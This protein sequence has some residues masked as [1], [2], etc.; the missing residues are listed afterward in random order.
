MSVRFQLY[1]LLATVGICLTLLRPETGLAEDFLEQIHNI[2][3][4]QTVARLERPNGMQ[5]VP[6]L[7]FAWDRKNKKTYFIDSN[8]HRFHL[9]FLRSHY[10][11]TES[12]KAFFEHQYVS[13]NRRWVLGAIAWQPV[14][15]RY[16]FELWEG[17]TADAKLID[18]TRRV[19]Q[20]AFYA[21]LSFKANSAAQERTIAEVSNLDVVKLSQLMPKQAVQAIVTGNVVGRLRRSQGKLDET[22]RREEIL[23]LT[24]VPVTLPPVSGIISGVQSSPLSHLNMLTRMW[25]APNVYMAGAVERFASLEGQWVALKVTKNNVTVQPASAEAIALR[26]ATLRSRH[27]TQLP[28]AKIESPGFLDL[29]NSQCRDV[30][31]VGAKAANLAKLYQARLS[32]VQVPPGY[33]IPF[34]YYSEFAQSFGMRQ[35]VDAMLAMAD[36]QA[37]ANARQTALKK[38]RDEIERAPLSEETEKQIRQQYRDF[39]KGR[40]IFARSSTNAED[41]PHFNGAGLYTSVPNI[42]SEDAYVAAVKVVWASIWNFS[43]FEAREAA[44]IDHF[45]VYPAVLIMVGID[46]DSAGVMITTD[47]FQLDPLRDAVYI[48]A[49]RG[50]GMKVVDGHKAPEQIVFHSRS[51]TYQIL[52][53]SDEDSQLV[54]D[55]QGGLKEIPAATGQ[56]ILNE[57]QVRQ[58]A[59]AGLQIKRLFNHKHQDIEWV[60][61]GEQL[62]IVQSRPYLGQ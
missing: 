22:Y 23:L 24:D 27:T 3:D 31:R 10:L 13:N 58:L 18:T 5:P 15:S 8:K 48:N 21:P 59:N 41:L 46:A 35:K 61:K 9:D 45:Q 17:D 56:A 19:L 7:M 37:E 11:T 32:N 60:M 34:Y 29:S 43:A 52:G 26:K 62:Y 42:T 33:V 49:K 25:R 36:F 16:T 47:P 30:K 1:H 54:F 20:Q 38:L 53:Y 12:G 51:N 14:I 50:L 57:A 44:G 2:N 28:K 40:S 6:N 55:D 4:F 39:A